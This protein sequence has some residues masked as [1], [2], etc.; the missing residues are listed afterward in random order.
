MT[1]QIVVGNGVSLPELKSEKNSLISRIKVVDNLIKAIEEY[2][3]SKPISEENN[4]S[5]LEDNSDL[6]ALSAY[7]GSLR[8][9]KEK[10]KPMTTK[11]LLE[12]LA[13]RGKVSKA[14]NKLTSLYSS[15]YGAIGNKRVEKL[16]DGTWGLTSWNS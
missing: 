12:E 9:L 14:Y 5:P 7:E 15:L 13:K 3:K 8:I 10:G 11:Q 6:S 16:E 2:E 1:K 4:S